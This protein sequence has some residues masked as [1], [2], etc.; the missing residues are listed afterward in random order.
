MAAAALTE[1]KQVDQYSADGLRPVFLRKDLAGMAELIEICFGPTMDESGRAAVNEMRMIS[2]YGTL[3]FLLNS[4][5]HFMGGLEQGFVWIDQERLIGNTSV[6]R[7]NYPRALGTGF[8]IANVAVHPDY[9]RQGVAQAMMRASLDLIRQKGGNFAI[10][11][12][13][14]TNEGARNLYTRLG[15]REERIFVR[16]HRSLHLRPPPRLDDLPFMTL[17]Q[18]NEWR[19]EYELAQLVRP[20]SRGGLGWLRPTYPDFFRPSLLRAMGTFVTGQSEEHIIVRAEDERSLLG[21]LRVTSSFGGADRFELL[22]HPAHQGQL[23]AP[24]INYALRRVNGY[25]SVI[26]EHPADDLAVTNLLTQYSFERRYTL[27]HMRYD[28]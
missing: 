7:A 26:M 12:V 21:A 22:V 25:H 11:Q 16:W 1:Q 17:R 8:I 5:D 3:M 27:I 13:D 4:L 9:R 18:P 15:F 19:A 10:L 6:S 20:N 2:K 24:L 23:E 14:A 28:L